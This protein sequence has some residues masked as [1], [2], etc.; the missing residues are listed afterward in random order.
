MRV[1]DHVVCPQ[2]PDQLDVRSPADGGDVGPEV[3]GALHGGGAD[4]AGRAVDE[5][6]PVRADARAQ[7]AERQDGAVAYRGG[8]L[9]AQAAWTGP[10]SSVPRIRHLGRGNLWSAA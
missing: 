3:P 6:A 10:A 5:D 9:E 8:V 4:G 1:V 2:R 7:A